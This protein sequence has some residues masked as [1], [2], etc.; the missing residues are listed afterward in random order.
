VTAR[1][2]EPETPAL[3]ATL[4][5]LAHD[6]TPIPLRLG[7]LSRKDTLE[8]VDAL[9]GPE[10]PVSPDLGERVW[11]TAAGHPLMI[12]EAMRALATGGWL[13]GAPEL[14]LPERVRE[15][16][17]RRLSRLSEPA[18]RLAAVAAVIARE[19]DP[20]LLQRAAGV[21]AQEAAD[22]VDELLRHRVLQSSGERLA[23][24]HDRIRDVAYRQLS[25]PR[26]RLLHRQVAQAIEA[27]YQR[28][29][30]PH[31][32]ALGLH[33]REAEAWEEASGI[34]VRPP[35]RLWPGRPIARRWPA[36]TR[37][38]LG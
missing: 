4:H 37:P 19:F 13:P 17:G 30:E 1:E 11:A 25:R 2:E 21:G 29:L 5:A 7:P 26:R 3:V 24:T 36:S 8:L 20:A 33:Y 10:A 32:L 31:A 12:V 27:L 22:G 28:H 38:W 9:A 15:L 14:T 35:A 6:A 16:I 34:S 23:F 18:Q